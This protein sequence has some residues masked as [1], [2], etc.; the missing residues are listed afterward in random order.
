MKKSSKKNKT[1]GENMEIIDIPQSARCRL[2]IILTTL[3]SG[4]VSRQRIV[5]GLDDGGARLSLSE[6]KRL[7]E[8]IIEMSRPKFGRLFGRCFPYQAS[9]ILGEERYELIAPS[10]GRSEDDWRFDEGE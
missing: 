5:I 9:L 3:K 8:V 6:A 10:S 1:K 4:E 2:E 7:A